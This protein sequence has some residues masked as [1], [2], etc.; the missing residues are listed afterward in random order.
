VL[1]AGT[2]ANYLMLT[3]LGGVAEF[4]RDLIRARTSEGRER[5]K[6]RGVKLGR[7]PN[8]TEHQRRE[9]IR[10]HDC[11][12]RAAARHRPQLH[13]VAQHDFRLTARRANLSDDEATIR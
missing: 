7:K 2:D 9:A 11:R 6:A 10:R 13:R 12:R 4:E 1:E 5:A 3:V 8:L